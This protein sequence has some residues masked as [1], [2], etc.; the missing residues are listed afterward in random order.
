MSRSRAYRSPEYFQVGGVLSQTSPSYVTRAADRRFEQAIV[1]GQFCYIFD[2]PQTGKT[3]LL[4]RA[5]R[6]L[7]GLRHHCVTVDLACLG[8]TALDSQ[9]WYVSLTRLLARKLRLE[10]DFRAWLEARSFLPPV[11]Y[12]SELLEDVALA[13]LDGPIAIFL[14]NIE[15]VLELA[16][17]VEEIF[18]LLKHHQRHERICFA[19][20]GATAPAALVRDLRHSP[21]PDG[22]A[23]DLEPF[24][25]E[26]ASRDALD[27]RPLA[28]GLIGSVKTPPETLAVALE[29]TGGQPLLTQWLCREIVDRAHREPRWPPPTMPQIWVAHLVQSQVV[30]EWELGERAHHFSSIRDRLLRQDSAPALLDLYGRILQKGA[31]DCA[32]ADPALQ[33]ALC[34]LGLTLVE[35]GQIRVCNRIY[36]RIFNAHWLTRAIASVQPDCIQVVTRQEQSLLGLL[37]VMENKPFGEVLYEVLA[38]VVLKLMDAFRA[39]R[40]T[41]F[42]IDAEY[43]EIWSLVARGHGVGKPDVGISSDRDDTIGQLSAQLN[44][45]FYYN[46]LDAPLEYRYEPGSVRNPLTIEGAPGRYFNHSILVLPL[47]DD[48][49]QA[50]GVVRLANHLHDT[51][52]PSAPLRERLDLAGFTP[53][54][55]AEFYEYAPALC[56]LLDRIKSSYQLTQRLRASEALAQ[57]TRSLSH[58]RLDADEIVVRVMAAAKQLTHAD[59]TTLWILDDTK[60]RLWTKI[61]REDGTFLELTLSVGE[62]FAGQVAQTGKTLSIPF[63]L[64]D[65][66]GSETAKQTDRRTGYRTCSLLCMPVRNPEGETIAVAQLVNRRKHGDYPVYNPA[67]WPEAPEVFRVSFDSQCENYMRIFNDQVGVALQ[68]AHQYTEAKQRAA[69]HVDS[70]VGETL[71]MLDRLTDSQGFDEVLETT[72]RSIAL[73]VGTAVRADRTRIVLLDET[74]QAFKTIVAESGARSEPV[75]NSAIIRPVTVRLVRGRGFIGEA[76][77]TQQPI[78]VPYDCYDDPRSALLCQEDRRTN[79]RTATLLAIPVLDRAGQPIAIVQFLN[80]LLPTLSGDE[81]LENRLDRRGFTAADLGHV[82]RDMPILRAILESFRTYHRAHPEKQA[83]AALLDATRRVTAAEAAN[84][85]T[86]AIATPSFDPDGDLADRDRFDDLLARIM[87]AAKILMNADR[88]TLWLLDEAQQQLWTKVRFADGLQRELRIPIGAGYVGR[89]AETRTALSI[90]Y[91]LYD[92]P[93]SETA[94]RTDRQ[95]GYRTCSLLCAPVF[96]PDGTIL[97]VTQLV[98]KRKPN[99]PTQLLS[100]ELPVPDCFEIGF[101]DSDLR[102][103][104]I[105]NNQ[106]GAALQNSVLIDALKRQERSLRATISP[107]FSASESDRTGG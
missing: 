98:N 40:V 55:E 67:T 83:A 58:S 32:D 99:T 16:F 72:L 28:N 85:P 57:A 52:N 106:A 36:R 61:A 9:Q 13:Q 38:P 14:D 37:P 30:N 87:D 73:R 25:F 18:A 84:G 17:R 63:D 93:G 2:A 49:E 27:L 24:R 20:A 77:A 75:G 19:V 70:V 62:G 82:E 4:L 34:A 103:L 43:S 22:R 86:D 92:D 102:S 8:S 81:L 21:F 41:L 51:Y 95:T 33:H 3:S 104:D 96:S 89:V 97:G 71:A 78:F 53:S 56:R 74:Q 29:W 31:M 47:F 105:F 80:K 64:Y 23:I 44:S 39:D 12:L 66:P 90:P 15:A 101:D 26:P 107:N 48:N 60:Q 5:E 79:Y 1:A 6:R 10:F 91:D 46:S 59:R 68:N 94:R 50:V 42:A 69:V 100:Y 45:P 35:D 11:Q 65:R 7:R 76:I 88:S 54:H